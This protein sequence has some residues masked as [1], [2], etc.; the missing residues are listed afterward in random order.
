MYEKA[1]LIEGA[2]I[3]CESGRP[4]RT[5]L[6]KYPIHLLRVATEPAKGTVPG[7]AICDSPEKFLVQFET[8]ARGAVDGVV[9]I[10]TTCNTVLS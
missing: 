1:S 10:D 2:V 8:I 5:D 4:F 3:L 9:L 7:A 6:V